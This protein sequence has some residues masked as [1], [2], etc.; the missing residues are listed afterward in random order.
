MTQ[1]LPVASRSQAWR[2]ARSLFRAH[3]GMFRATVGLHLLAALAG[4]AG[5]RLLG[6]LVQ[7]V[8][9]GT[10]TGQLDRLAATLAGFVLLQS[11]L[12]RY[13]YLA[14]ARLG[15][16]VL[17][18]L[19]EEF[20][21]RVLS[22]PLGTVES[23]GT[24]D[25][26][27]RTTRDVDA[28]SKCVR[29]AVPETTIAL[30]T[31]GLVVVALIAVDPVL[32]APLLVGVPITVA[33][34]RWYVRRAPSGYLRQNAAY[35]EVT[36]GLTETVEGARTVEALGRQGQRVARTDR[37]LYRSWRAERY[38]L[39]LRTVWWPVI[40]VSYVIP[41]VLTLLTGGWMY[42]RGTVTLGALTAAVVYVQ[43]LIHPLD[44]LLSWLDE[45][46]VGAASLARLLGVAEAPQ[47]P[48]RDAPAPDGS[49]LEVRGVRFGYVEGREV[50]HGVDLT[51][52]PGER[53][54]VVGPSGAG[55]STLGRL[56]A[57][58]HQ[59]TEGS[60]TVGGVPLSE[61][62]P[63]RLRAE[64]ALVSQ[65]HH[66]FVGTLRD[67]V[68]MARPRAPE[69]DVRT[70]L[71]AVHAL[72]WADGLPD[73]LDTVIGD[74]GLPLTAAQAQQVALARLI[75]ADPHTLV[76][77][78]ATALL[79]P[80]AARDLERSLAAVVH[81][82]TVV[83]IAHRLFSAHDADRVAVVEDGRITELGSHDELVAANGSYAALWREWQGEAPEK[84]PD[85]ARAR[86][87]EDAP[88]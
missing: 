86:P 59:P 6:E 51:L 23:A 34:T 84:P 28:L 60:V 65:E 18:R 13:A 40:E 46:Q 52:R 48:R 54:A 37:D 79:D 26:L 69:P 87:R 80:R 67:N 83:A 57:G 24:G 8:Q 64:V 31:G 58:L 45:L 16:Q 62:A 43:Q 14:S 85:T 9:R 33:G 38:T 5:P 32:A 1:A 20:I 70:A 29:L 74:G 81:G 82:R 21:A 66:V 76:L 73:G 55:K 68:A 35:S 42:L 56:L 63:D 12:I 44:R 19:R 88:L 53:L 36:D 10:P 47:P 4:L 25:L 71:A 78:E 77:D 7:E 17:A 2:Y 41:M 3:P 49:P 72:E 11:V 27:T 50:L 39:F 75:L 15:E 61:L 30:L 22:L